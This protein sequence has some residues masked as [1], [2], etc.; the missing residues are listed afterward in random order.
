LSVAILL[1]FFSRSLGRGLQRLPRDTRH[2]EDSIH[3]SRVVWQGED[4]GF[5][6]KGSRTGRN[7]GSGLGN[8]STTA[9]SGRSPSRG[10]E[11][12]GGLVTKPKCFYINIPR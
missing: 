6:G 8:W 1:L 2:S 5:K 9:E 10:W 4:V 3:D 7:Q 12:A 11:G